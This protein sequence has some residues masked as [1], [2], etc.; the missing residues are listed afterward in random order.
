MLGSCTWRKSSHPEGRSVVIEAVCR[1]V[2]RR[3]PS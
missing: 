1:Q 2:Y 3:R